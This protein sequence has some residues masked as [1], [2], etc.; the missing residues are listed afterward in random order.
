MG[1][2]RA[3]EGLRHEFRSFIDLVLFLSLIYLK[4]TFSVCQHWVED[5][6]FSG[7]SLCC[8]LQMMIV[9]QFPL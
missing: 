9:V 1:L 2:L 8:C 5:F 7:S 4:F 6:D 3:V